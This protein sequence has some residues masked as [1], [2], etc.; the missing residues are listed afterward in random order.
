[1]KRALAA[2]IAISLAAWSPAG[3]DDGGRMSSS[4]SSRTT[5]DHYVD[6]HHR[7]PA[8]GFVWVGRWHDP[9][10]SWDDG[11]FSDLKYGRDDRYRYRPRPHGDVEVV[12]GEARYQYDR[13]YPYRRYDDHRGRRY[14]WH[15][16]AHDGS[17]SVGCRTQWVWSDR[18]RE[19][20][21]V[22]ICS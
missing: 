5:Y 2:S 4:W 12:N 7:R 6:R 20:V 18:D 3:A 21:P 9:L 19:Q 11:F 8:P 13:G 10:S 1:M 14:G 17:A 22:R 15:E 16:P